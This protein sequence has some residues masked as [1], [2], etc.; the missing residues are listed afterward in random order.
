MTGVRLVP[1]DEALERALQ[2]PGLARLT[3]AA[4]S[5]PFPARL[6]VRVA[7]L[8]QVAG[9]VAALTGDP[10]VDPALPTSYDPGTYADSSDWWAPRAPPVP[11]CWRRSR[12]SPQR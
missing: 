8:P 5:N 12:S 1:A 4:G 3:E 7:G 10:A 6:E 2:R 11:A 9:L